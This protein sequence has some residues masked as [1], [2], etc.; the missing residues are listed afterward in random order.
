MYEVNAHLLQIPV[1]LAFF[2]AFVGLAPFAV[3]FTEFGKTK[4][5]MFLAFPVGTVGVIGVAAFFAH[6]FNDTILY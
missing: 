2:M 4:V 5:A 1:V 6:F 3:M